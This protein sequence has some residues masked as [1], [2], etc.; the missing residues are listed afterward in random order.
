MQ[1]GTHVYRIEEMLCESLIYINR[2]HSVLIRHDWHFPQHQQKQRKNGST[3][4]I[5]PAEGVET[6]LSRKAPS[7]LY[8]EI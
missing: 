2:F 8:G 4:I 3:W 7:A 5:E 1:T 6:Y